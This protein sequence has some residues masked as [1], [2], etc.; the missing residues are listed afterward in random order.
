MLGTRRGAMIA[1]ARCRGDGLLH[2]SGFRPGERS[3]PSLLPL[4]QSHLLPVTTM[5]EISVVIPCYN[6]APYLD[7]ALSSVFAQ[8]L[9]PREVVVVDD[10]S[11]DQSAQIAQRYDVRLV[12][13]PS[14]IGNAAARN[15]GLRRARGDLVAWFDADDVWE[16]EHL[17]TVVP[18][19]ERFPDA[20]L[21][22]SLV[23]MFGDQ[24]DVW[25]AL[26]PA[27][28]PVDAHDACLRQTILPHNAVL[29]RRAEVLAT[30]GYDERLRVASDYDLWLRLSQRFPFV[31]T[32][33]ITCNWRRHS[34][35]MSRNMQRYWAGEY[36]SRRRYRA[37]VAA[38]R[39]AQALA[40]VDECM[41]EIWRG[42][43]ATA[44]HS[45]D[46]RDFDFHLSMVSA[47]P[48]ALALAPGYRVQRAL[49]P[50]ACVLDM[51]P[52]RPARAIRRFAS[53]AVLRTA[54][55]AVG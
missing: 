44:W 27:E 55:S 49:L 11:T 50:A 13:I 45:R 46:G 30:G 9:R 29:V 2:P 17:A 8:T 3:L 54:G 10:G 19:L 32:H 25:P 42:H 53:R 21:A 22:F 16:P 51:C 36:D 18:L 7:A 12:R 33:A 35:Q 43:L 6:A 28:V 23:R 41:R 47:V 26:L 39:D 14:N 48:G 52:T 34:G 24:T 31:C 40:S 37:E 1:R 4:R 5:S 38:R 15:V 20:V